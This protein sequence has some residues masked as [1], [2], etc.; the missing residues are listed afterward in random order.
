MYRRCGEPYEDTPNH[1][2]EFAQLGPELWMARR[3]GDV[4]RE[5]RVM[6]GCRSVA[7]LVRWLRSCRAN[8]EPSE[9][10]AAHEEK[11][12]GPRR[13]SAV[14]VHTLQLFGGCQRDRIWGK[15]ESYAPILQP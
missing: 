13:E 2:V 3:T 15:R 14:D 8:T 9:G 5:R 4:L 12:R 10:C 1:D 6:D 7:L 11:V